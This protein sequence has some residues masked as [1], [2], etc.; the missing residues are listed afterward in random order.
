MRDTVRNLGGKGGCSELA[1]AQIQLVVRSASPIWCYAM[2]QQG[3]LA[4]LLLWT[5]LWTPGPHCAQQRRS[6]V[7]VRMIGMPVHV[8]DRIVA[9]KGFKYNMIQMESNTS[10]TMCELLD[11]SSG[12]FK[13]E[14]V[15]QQSRDDLVQKNNRDASVFPCHFYFFFSE[16]TSYFPV[17]LWSNRKQEHPRKVKSLLQNYRRSSPTESKCRIETSVC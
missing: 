6:S 2:H 10:C 16:A 5:C 11:F 7:D 1:P 8:C 9:I 15:A 4:V 14:T 3:H 12:F 13:Y 17:E